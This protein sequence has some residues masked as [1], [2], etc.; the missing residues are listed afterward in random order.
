MH[1]KP[2]PPSC[3]ANPFKMTASDIYHPAGEQDYGF[4]LPEHGG[5]PL[6]VES[7]LRL[8]SAGL[9]MVTHG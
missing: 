3:L 1:M 5:T 2:N 6:Y 9:A 8:N 4:G 7:M